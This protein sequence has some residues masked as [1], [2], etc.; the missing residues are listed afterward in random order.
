MNSRQRRQARRAAEQLTDIRH[1]TRHSLPPKGSNRNGGT[2][3]TSTQRNSEGR[4]SEWSAPQ[5]LPYSIAVTAHQT[6]WDQTRTN[7]T[8]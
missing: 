7:Q 2:K 8:V 6:A 3:L 4:R 5:V 1:L